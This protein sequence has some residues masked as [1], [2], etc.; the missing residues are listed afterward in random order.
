MSYIATVLTRSGADW[1]GRDADLSD[2]DDLDALADVLRDDGVDVALCLIEE[3]DEYVAVVR[4]DGDAD[5]P[6]VFLSDKRVLDSTGVAA[7]LLADALEAAVVSLADDDEEEDDDE[8]GRPEVEP[9]GDDNL[10]GDLG[11][12]GER[13]TSLC[14]QE[15]MLPSDVIFAVGDDLGAGDVLEKVRGV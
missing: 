9:V 12:S 14:A 7:R 10:L 4:V 5:E 8:S 3:D 15:G 6:R 2:V 13:L 11:V 1:S